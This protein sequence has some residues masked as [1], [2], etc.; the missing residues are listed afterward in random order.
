MISCF[1]S[2]D[3]TGLI[4]VYDTTTV[5]ETTTTTSMAPTTSTT[6]T[7][8]TAPP[9]TAPPTV[10][11]LNELKVDVKSTGNWQRKFISIYES[12]PSAVG[13]GLL[14]GIFVGTLL[15]A[16]IIGD[17]PVLARH[18]KFKGMYN[19]KNRNLCSKRELKIEYFEQSKNRVRVQH[20]NVGTVQKMN[21]IEK[22]KRNLSKITVRAPAKTSLDT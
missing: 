2:L 22:N 17:L 13:V 9:T 15:I 21:F 16:I 6:P 14:G 4:S 3:A 20:Q 5:E 12:R 8:T 10:I 19:I 1:K 7:T 11:N 18:I